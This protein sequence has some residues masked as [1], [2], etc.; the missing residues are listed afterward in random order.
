MSSPSSSQKVLEEMQL[1][2][3]GLPVEI[4]TIIYDLY[5]PLSIRLREKNNSEPAILRT[6]KQI[7]QEALWVLRQRHFISLDTR[8]NLVCSYID[9]A[10]SPRGRS[11]FEHPLAGDWRLA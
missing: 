9:V 2:F 1:D 11:S 4:R 6:S 10:R 7:H 5:L 8:P 3:L